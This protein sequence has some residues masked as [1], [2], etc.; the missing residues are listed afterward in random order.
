MSE[1]RAAA[2][3]SVDIGGTFTDIV[4]EAE[5][6][7]ATAKVLTTPAA[8]EEGV[9]NGIEVALAEA[10]LNASALSLVLHG[11]TLATNAI[12]ER[13]GAKTAFVTTEG[14]RDVLEIGYESRYDQYD[15][16]IEKPAPLV[17]RK[18]RLPVAERVDLT[19]QVLKPLDEGMVEALVPELEAAEIESV[20]IGY[21][22]AYANPDHERRTRDL[23]AAR[24]PDMS[25]SI[26]SEVCPEIREYERFT[27]TS[28]NAY[29][30][31]LMAS[32]L[33]RLRDRLGTMGVDCPV[34]LMTSGG[35]LTTL[36]NAMQFPIRLVESGPAGGAILATKVAEEMGLDKV[37]SFDMGGTT[38]KIS[39]IGDYRPQTARE[40]EVDRAA[41]FTKG[42]GLP[43]RIPVIEMVEI[44]AGG[45]SIARLDSLG[46]ITIG[47]DSAGADPGPAAYGRGGDRP[48]ITDADVALGKI[49]PASFAG[50]NVA[51]YPEKSEATIMRD[52]GSPLGV[53]DVLTAAYGITEM[54][55]ETMSNAA[56]VHAVEQGKA[57]NEHSL[58]AF[59]GAAPLHAGRLAEKLGID[60]I[61]VPTD[62]G[63]GS[64]VGFLEAPIAYEVVRSR[65]MRLTAFNP[66]IVN[67]LMQEMRDEALAV[68]RA[69]EPDADVVERRVAFMRYVGQGHEITIELPNGDFTDND[70]QAVQKAFDTEYERHFR[71]T[72][73]NAETE[74]LT[75][76]LSLSVATPPPAP[77]G[78]AP[79]AS[80]ATPAGQRG[81]FGAKAGKMR[82]V[83]LFRRT[84]M[85]PGAGFDGPGIVIED[86][87][88]TYVPNGFS[89]RIAANGYIV[90]ERNGE[91]D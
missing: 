66:A 28:A 1:T 81:V 42:S 29:V 4:L 60:R 82:D 56:R 65:N 61:V 74:V 90:I 36:E 86:Q 34:L 35:G 46:R 12:L 73:P 77:L 80:A 9:I 84:D 49:D 62:A 53:P 59:G 64:A 47:P 48:T 39:L 41:R 20:A 3:L 69:A 21:M 76:A 44:G 33:A 91:S 31:P 23:L 10:G 30:R 14:F 11:T 52:V 50:G 17:P 89:A 37:I 75:W 83:P 58:I 32:Y 38:A 57:A 26:S 24:L 72:L 79:A 25:F 67:R 63:V 22:H 85:A 2:R 6:R 18:L 55:D 43:L 88:S 78:A 19:G 45:G 7:R 13:K 8:P 5:G 15:I 70:W 27:T 68:I 16:M 40:F 71:R 51:L 87:T 54:V